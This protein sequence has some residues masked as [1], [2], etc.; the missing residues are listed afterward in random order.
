M[1]RGDVRISLFLMYFKNVGGP[2]RVM[3][4]ITRVVHCVFETVKGKVSPTL[5]R[6]EATDRSVH[7]P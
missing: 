3:M 7:R 6:E 2:Y 5:M 1:L 4:Q